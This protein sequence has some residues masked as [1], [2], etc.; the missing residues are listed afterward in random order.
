MTE[1]E[2]IRATN[3][4]KVS[5]ALTILHDVLPGDDC[6]ITNIDL[7]EILRKLRISEQKLFQSYECKDK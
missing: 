5:A 4:V 7:F 3:R 1:I 6:G 2:Y